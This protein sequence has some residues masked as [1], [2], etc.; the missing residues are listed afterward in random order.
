[1]IVKEITQDGILY[2]RR[3]RYCGTSVCCAGILAL[4]LVQ[5]ARM[6]SSDYQSCHV[7]TVQCPNSQFVEIILVFQGNATLF[8]ISH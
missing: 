3:I 6:C 5:G 2:N 8:T 1:M 4:E 7:S